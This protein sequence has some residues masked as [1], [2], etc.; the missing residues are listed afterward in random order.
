MSHKYDSD[1]N[2]LK[3]NRKS[4]SS[5]EEQPYL[6]QLSYTRVPVTQGAMQHVADRFL[7]FIHRDDGYLKVKRELDSST[8]HFTWTFT[9]G[10]WAK[11]YV[12]SRVEYYD[13]AYG[14][15]LLLSKI[16]A[17]EEG[18]SRPTRDTFRS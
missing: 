6:A 10:Q 7:Y 5:S 2:L 16:V 12:Y 11:H 17:V 15:E 1:G 3:N 8:V 18:R 14:L 4:A 9:A 13:V